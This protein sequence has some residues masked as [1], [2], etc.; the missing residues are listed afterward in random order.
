MK[1]IAGS[2]LIL[3]ILLAGAIAQQ[4]KGAVNDEAAL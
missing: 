1:K 4:K 2:V 3:S